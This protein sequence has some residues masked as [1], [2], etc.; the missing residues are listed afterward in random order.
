MKSLLLRRI[1]HY[2]RRTGMPP[3]TFGRLAVRDPLLV[4]D[5]RGGRE[6]RPRTQTRVTAFLDRAE[7]D[8]KAKRRRP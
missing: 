8:R 6:L 5:L 3:T 4:A 2:L 1:E 7:R